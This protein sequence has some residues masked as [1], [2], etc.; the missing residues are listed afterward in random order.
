MNYPKDI[1]IK[2][3]PFV[4]PFNLTFCPNLLNLITFTLIKKAI[5][6]NENRRTD[7]HK[8]KTRHFRYISIKEHT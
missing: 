8:P 4:Y 2:I 6:L 1:T 5:A 7:L 3:F